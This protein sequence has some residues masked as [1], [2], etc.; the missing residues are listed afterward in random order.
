MKA[1]KRMRMGKE[2][3][4]KIGIGNGKR[5]LIVATMNVDDLRSKE[6]REILAKRHEKDEN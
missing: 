6:T 2:G 3:I 1:R 5:R 4:K